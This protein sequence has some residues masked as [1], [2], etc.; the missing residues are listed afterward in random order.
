MYGTQPT[1]LSHKDYD[2]HKTFG[3]IV[4]TNKDAH[5]IPPSFEPEYLTDAGLDM[6]DQ[7]AMGLPFG[8]TDVTQAELCID[9][10]LEMVSPFDLEKVTHA[11]ALGGF[12]IRASLDAARKLGWFDAFFNIRHPQLD[13][14]DSIRLAMCSGA[15]EKRSVSVGT[16][17]F[18]EWQGYQ[19]MVMP[20][21]DL[22]QT[23]TV[24]HNWSIKGWKSINGVS[25]LI[26]KSWQGDKVGDK[27]FQYFPREVIN[28]IFSVS[29]TVAFT[30]T[31]VKPA[32]IQTVDLPLLQWIW[33]HLMGYWY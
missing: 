25:M 5:V 18:K 27:G 20:N 8:C 3:S 12:D 1:K 21:P 7:D 31:Q 6:P 26:G 29:G 32:N 9:E 24:W 19:G 30:A 15:P 16:P 4:F 2:F 14:F 17:W 23:L 28:S 33:S 13:M 11:N 22:N 10:T